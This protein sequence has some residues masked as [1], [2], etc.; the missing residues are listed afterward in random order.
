MK[1]KIYMLGLKVIGT[2]LGCMIWTLRK[3]TGYKDE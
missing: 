2:I 1:D 3:L